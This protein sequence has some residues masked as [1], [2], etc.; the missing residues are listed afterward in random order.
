MVRNLSEVGDPAGLVDEQKLIIGP[1]VG[2]PSSIWRIESRHNKTYPHSAYVDLGAEKH[3]STL[4]LFDTHNKG[5][6]VISAGKPGAWREVATY[7]C[8]RYMH[9]A[10]VPLD[11]TSRYL[12]LTR[13]SAGAQFTEI[14]IY[15]YTPEAYRRMLERKAAEA[16]AKAEKEAAVARAMAEM[17]KRPLVDLGAPFGKVYLVDEIDCAKTTP[18]RAFVEDPR[19]AS[20]V[21]TILG[22][23]CRV[24]KKTLGECAYVCYRIGRMKLLQPGAAYVLSVEYP[25]DAPRGMVIMNAGNECS[26]GIHTGSALG[27]AFHPKY[28]NNNSESYATP[29]SGRYERWNMLFFLHDRFPNREFLR[30]D[31][32]RALVPDEGFTVT[33]AQF[34]ARNIPASRGAAVRGIRLYAV[35]EPERLYVKPVLPPKGLPHRHIFW[36]EEMADGVIGSAKNTKKGIAEP[37]DWYRYKANLMHFL[38][39]DTYCRDLLEF[40]ACQ[41][42]D[43]TEYGGN[44]W[45]YFNYEHKGLWERIVRLMGAEGFNVLPYYEYSGSK[46]Q[47][48][49]GEQARAKPLTRDDSYTHIKWRDKYNAD[50]TDPDTCEDF[51]KM[52]DLTV[53]RHRKKANFVG[54]W[55]R[56]R[57]QLPIGFGDG[58]RARFAK[59]ANGGKTVS[60]DDLKGDAG[61][62]GR[63]YEWWYGKRRQFLVAMRDHLRAGGVNAVMLFTADASEPGTSFPSWDPSIVT[64]DVARWAPVLKQEIHKRGERAVTAVHIDEVVKEHRYLEALK[65]EPL[66]WGGWEVNHS[67]PPSDPERYKETEGVVLSH[68]INRAYTVA[69]PATFDAFRAPSGLFALRHYTLNENM[70]FDK[71][72]KEK[73][74]YFVVD[75]ERAG[76]CCMLAEARA[77]AN[78]DP[79]YLGYLMASSFNRGYP[80]YV[81]RFNLAFLALPALP[82]EVVKDACSDRDVVVRAIETPSHGTY[83]AVVNTGLVPKSNVTVR[84]GAG[85]VH[86]VVKG[87]ILPRRGSGVV[88]SLAP[89][90][91]K[92]WHRK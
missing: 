86:D 42:W 50:I 65:A 5:D 30:G 82:S 8:G 39:I 53:I 18:D 89:C 63:Y 52:L 29:L 87:E 44:K 62:L 14:A 20:Q 36:R 13:M 37:L 59:E 77:V 75:F 73:L 56:P 9:W 79:W 17:K 21:E 57:S 34:S 28:V 49:L 76:P 74:G 11:L 88:T 1:P 51:K 70:M 64:D 3:L 91:L 48:G 90:E 78:G 60:R 2:K 83:F 55:L 4:W 41:H 71:D 72:D 25:E 80:E 85:T 43:S 16:K 35:P 54:A 6:V 38:G 24:L 12:R 66:N 23:P 69:D 19:G 81:R 68:C 32:E 40:G 26:R 92:T 46:G 10:K 58:T 33:I 45:V 15:E 61:L 27:D 7:D 31:K 22:K 84:L 47:Q 67:S